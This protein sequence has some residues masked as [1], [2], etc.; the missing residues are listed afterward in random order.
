MIVTLDRTDWGA[1]VTTSTAPA[2][3]PYIDFDRI[4][5]GRKSNLGSIYIGSFPIGAQIPP[6]SF[7]VIVFCA[8][9]VQPDPKAYHVRHVIFCRLDDSSLTPA[10]FSRAMAVAERV[11]VHVEKGERVLV[12]CAMGVNRSSLVASLAMMLVTGKPGWWVAEWVR[13]TRRPQCGMRALAN[14]SFYAAVSLLKKLPVPG[15]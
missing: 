1:E 4:L 10:M 6:G 7:D 15:L 5:D 13:T 14:R 12:T 2:R 8:R 9:E 3:E 11:A